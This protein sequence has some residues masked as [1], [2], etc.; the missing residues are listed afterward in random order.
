LRT[1]LTETGAFDA[2][3]PASVYASGPKSFGTE[4]AGAI[5][6]F[7]AIASV[8]VDGVERELASLPA[9]D[10]KSDDECPPQAESANVKHTADAS[11]RDGIRMCLLSRYNVTTRIRHNPVPLKNC[12]TEC[13]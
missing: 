1:K 5:A 3:R 9:V 11:A 13:K 12:C 7:V 6:P 8:V 2:R 10:G 4:I